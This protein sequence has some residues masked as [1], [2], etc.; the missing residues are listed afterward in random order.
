[1]HEYERQRE[2]N[3]SS[4]IGEWWL[5]KWWT[6]DG[7][8]IRSLEGDDVELLAIFCLL[9]KARDDVFRDADEF[10]EQIVGYKM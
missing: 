1:M 4:R 8:D 10:S 6:Y 9:A 7:D 2:C 5:G 3:T